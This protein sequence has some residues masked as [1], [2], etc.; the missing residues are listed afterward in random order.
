[1]AQGEYQSSAV[2]AESR[3]SQAG[4]NPGS[5]GPEDGCQNEEQSSSDDDEQVIM[6]VDIKERGTVG[7]CYY[8]G[9]EDKLYILCDVQSGGKE[10]IEMC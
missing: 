8:V 3:R 4:I 5:C 2:P 6:A 1:L 7:C 10:A 9:Q